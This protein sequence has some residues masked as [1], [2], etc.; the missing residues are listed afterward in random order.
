MNKRI[1]AI[2]ACQGTGKTNLS[3]ELAGFLKK[4]GKNTVLINE[5]ARECP[6]PI[7]QVADERTQTWISVKQVLKELELINNKLPDFEQECQKLIGKLQN[8]AKAKAEMQAFTP[9]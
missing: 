9:Q 3:Y 6:F 4:L 1:I 5:L 8:Y 7:N 2:S